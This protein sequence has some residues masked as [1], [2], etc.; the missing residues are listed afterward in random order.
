M[1]DIKQAIERLERMT[2]E[3]APGEDARLDA[4]EL[5]AVLLVLRL[6]KDEKTIDPNDIY[7]LCDRKKCGENHNCYVCNHTTDIR[8]AVNFDLV[9]SPRS[10]FIENAR[11]R[12][13]WLEDSGNI[14]CS[15]CHTIWL[16]RK[17]N[18]CPNCGALMTSEVTT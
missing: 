5:D 18:Y 12:G 6:L 14:A 15:H 16:Y 1:T 10:V 11:P 9:E 7:Y 17:T 8:H 13:E 4:D 2:A 3:P